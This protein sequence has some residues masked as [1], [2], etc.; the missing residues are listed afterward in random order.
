MI[1]G[2][3]TG[4][5]ELV[6]AARGGCANSFALLT[7]R[8]FGLVYT[9]AYARLRDHD[10]AQDLS[11]E[12]F[13]RLYLGLA[14]LR[15]PQYFGTWVSRVTRNLASDWVRNRR[16]ASRLITFVPMEETDV[17]QKPGPAP[18]QR[19][20]LSQSE[21]MNELHRAILKLPLE[22]REILL[23][24]YYRG[25]TQQEIGTRLEMHHTTVGRHLQRAIARLQRW[26]REL[27][28]LALCT[29][30][31]LHPVHERRALVRSLAI[32]SAAA[33]LSGEAKSS[34]A[35]AATDGFGSLAGAASPVS[36]S[37]VAQSTGTVPLQAGMLVSKGTIM[38]AKTKAA[39]V[40]LAAV[41]ALGATYHSTHPGEL[42]QILQGTTPSTVRPKQPARTWSAS[43]VPTMGPG[44]EVFAGQI[45]P[46]IDQVVVRIKDVPGNLPQVQFDVPK[47][48]VM[49][50]PMKVVSAD[51]DRLSVIATGQFALDVARTSDALTGT[52]EVMMRKSAGMT[53]C[54]VELKR[55]PNSIPVARKLPAANV[56]TQSAE[57]LDH[58]TGEYMVSSGL[59]IK[60][61]RQ[62]GQ[63]FAQLTDR[64]PLRIYPV[65]EHRY[66][67]REVTDQLSFWA[68]SDGKIARL[69]LHNDRDTP[70]RKVQ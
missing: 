50:Y 69:V 26:S 61:T 12:V 16:R 37:A 34:L 63:L 45:G 10:V 41:G 17:E 68:G 56:A 47:A 32:V 5:L 33:A 22:Q 31:V 24:H 7:T 28:G 48:L 55:I 58:L 51:Q 23:L 59:S 14:T 36:A 2:P 60:I 67:F 19:E 43:Y 62:A 70:A 40:T 64:D 53:T 21:Q 46:N 38:A 49:E 35:S 4:D 54:A 66:Y 1:Q 27:D 39:L 42:K 6:L 11:Q 65:D 15:E 8:Y 29:S 25:M 52:A 9:L 13:L 57:S 30:T 3:Q 44:E 20:R 18:D